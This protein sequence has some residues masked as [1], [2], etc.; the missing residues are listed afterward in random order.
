GV[1]REIYVNVEDLITRLVTDIEKLHT[2]KDELA[3]LLEQF[4]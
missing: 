4:S 3:A 2:Y 1:L